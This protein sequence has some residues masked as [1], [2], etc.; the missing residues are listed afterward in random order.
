LVP[1]SAGTVPD[2][3]RRTKDE[4]GFV[5]ESTHKFSGRSER[6]IRMQLKFNFSLCTGCKICE[7][8]CSAYHERVFNPEKSRL[9]V[10]HEYRRNGIYINAKWCIFCKKCEYGCPESAISNNDRWMIVDVEKCTGC[11]AC[12]EICPMKVITVREDGK[13]L[14]CDLCEG[15]PK[16]IEWCPKGVISLK[17][18]TVTSDKA[19]L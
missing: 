16:C 11:Q 19:D 13:V 18:A 14:I 9:K 1:V 2:T 8:A 7:L 3:I 12:I 17:E 5:C 6:S 15:S 10:I 4:E